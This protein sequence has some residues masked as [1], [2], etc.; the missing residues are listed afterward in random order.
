MCGSQYA[1]IKGMDLTDMR[2]QPRLISVYSGLI[3]IRTIYSES[4]LSKNY[5]SMSRTIAYNNTLS[6]CV[7]NL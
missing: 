4:I 5:L 2:P 1:P 7:D 6:V 3:E